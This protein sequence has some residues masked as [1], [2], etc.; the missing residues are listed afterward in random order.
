MGNMRFHDFREKF[1]QGVNKTLVPSNIPIHNYR[2]K[3]V[4]SM[5]LYIHSVH[6]INPPLHST[7]D[8]EAFAMPPRT[9]TTPSNEDEHIP[10]TTARTTQS[11]PTV[12]D[13][14]LSAELLC[15]P[16]MVLSL[17]LESPDHNFHNFN[18]IYCNQ[19]Q[20]FVCHI[21]RNDKDYFN[22]TMRYRF[23]DS[24]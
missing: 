7:T 2:H 24:K 21:I 6:I 13:D 22:S 16:I 15:W 3:S 10:N 8:K 14:I 1:T 9:R 23:F 19:T 11:I 12:A 4:S 17:F 18:F 5:W 20:D